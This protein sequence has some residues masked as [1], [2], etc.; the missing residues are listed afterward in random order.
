VTA[1]AP[2]LILA[3]VEPSADAI[4][5]ALI[6][7]L[8]ERLSP[9]ARLV[10][11]G[12]AAMRAEGFESLFPIEPLA[13]IGAIDVLRAARL[14]A[15]RASDLA[16]LAEEAGAAGAV[17]I[18]GWAFSRLAATR[19]R[20]R[21]PA[22][23]LIKYVAP[24]IWASRPQRV[25][26]VRDHFDGVLSVLPF[27]P[28]L[29]EAAGVPA[30]FVGNPNFEEAARAPADAAGFRER[31]GLGAAPL[32]LFLL[33]SRRGE[34][35]RL[36][37][38]FRAAASLLQARVE[39]LRFASVIAPAV[40][41]EARAAFADWPSAPTLVGAKEKADAFASADVAIAA[42]GT[43]STELAIRGAPTLVAYRLD[44]LSAAWVRSVI[45]TPFVSVLNVAA[46]RAVIPEL[47]QERC[48]GPE[49]AKAALKLLIDA[50]ARR[51]QREGFQA[52]LPTLGLAGAPAADR[53]AE[54]IAAWIG[55]PAFKV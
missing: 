29:F 12:G 35:A 26:F 17:F 34:V 40:E 8:R 11:C 27:E 13:V 10:G 9:G 4:G 50:G 55:P 3:A 6:R 7:A 1:P 30:A 38:P 21:A 14:A 54:R 49:I 43:V 39:G 31:H 45:T 47:L 25:D 23:K 52:I 42:S 36:A 2:T 24:Q 48:T 15:R 32:A 20:K 37:G 19:F 5:A 28:R 51:A 16:A 33:G 44:P 22:T 18:D 53:A 41:A 46:G